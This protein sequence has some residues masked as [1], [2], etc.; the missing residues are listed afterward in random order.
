M[1]PREAPEIALTSEQAPRQVGR[2][3]NWLFHVTVGRRVA[4][5]QSATRGW[6]SDEPTG[7]L[8]SKTEIWAIQAPAN[9]QR[10]GRHHDPRHYS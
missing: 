5:A 2:P 3:R 10:R 6:R 8:E 4:I 9:L 1:M 7:G